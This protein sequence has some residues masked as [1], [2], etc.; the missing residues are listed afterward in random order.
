ML[1]RTLT[2]RN[3]YPPIDILQSVSRLMIDIADPT[4]LGAAR[5][6]QEMLA[7]YSQAEDLINI[8]AYQQG[9]QPK[10]RSGDEEYRLDQSLFT[11]R[12]G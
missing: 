2:E 8:G 7:T 5:K 12:S 9:Q 1:S 3:H 6:L 4:H 11:A 10:N